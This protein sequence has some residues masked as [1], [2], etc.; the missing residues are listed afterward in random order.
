MKERLVEINTSMLSLIARVNNIDKRIEE[1]E[2]KRD[3]EELHGEIHALVNSI[4]VDFNKKNQALQAL[5]ATKDGEL[6]AYKIKAYKVRV[7]PV[8]AQTKV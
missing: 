2:S 6:Q 7:K 1:L 4:V 5:A 3:M 8:Q